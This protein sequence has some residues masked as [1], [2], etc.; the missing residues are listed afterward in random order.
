MAADFRIAVGVVLVT[1]DRDAKSYFPTLFRQSTGTR[2]IVS[3]LTSCK[4]RAI[5]PDKPLALAHA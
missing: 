4:G 5:Q 2:A 3:L 1:V